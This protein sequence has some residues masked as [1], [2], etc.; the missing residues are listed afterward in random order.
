MMNSLLDFTNIESWQQE[1]SF[2]YDIHGLHR[3]IVNPEQ[4]V[5]LLHGTGFSAGTLLPLVHLMPENWDC[6]ISNVPG[7]GGSA[8]FDSRMPDWLEMADAL[9]ESIRKQMDVK[10]KGPVIGVG[11]SFGGALTLIAAS[12]NPDLFSRII[13]LDPIMLPQSISVLQYFM[14]AS[15]LWKFTTA[16]KSVNNRKYLWPTIEEMK[17]E[18][19][20]K[21]LY[22]NFDEKVMEHFLYSASHINRKGERELSCSPRW[23]ASIFSSFPKSL[24]TSVKKLSIKTDMIMAED[25][26]FFVPKGIEKSGK[27]NKNIEIHKF[28]KSHCFPM[29]QPAETAEYILQLLKKS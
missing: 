5:H 19:Y 24:W 16:F 7:H 29:E 12:R 13:L 15:G 8:W 10:N 18:L 27:K 1:T 23:E 20:P 25:T 11:H 17:S 14:R 21:R 26:F 22:R 28:G 9:A 4:R 6:Y 3:K 2:G